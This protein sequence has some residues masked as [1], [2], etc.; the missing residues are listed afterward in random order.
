MKSEEISL[1][2][3]SECVD[4]N[5]G[6]ASR[7]HSLCKKSD[8]GFWTGKC[9]MP[10]CQCKGYMT[11]EMKEKMQEQMEKEVAIVFK[12]KPY[13]IEDDTIIRLS[14]SKLKS[15]KARINFMKK[16]HRENE[17]DMFD[18]AGQSKRR[19]IVYP[20]GEKYERRH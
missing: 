17:I 14:Q 18:L 12:I 6:H 19:L 16:T 9:L 3:T 20:K 13:K 15:F 1:R 8:Y 4:P 7:D 2:Q 5:C 11:K 10:D